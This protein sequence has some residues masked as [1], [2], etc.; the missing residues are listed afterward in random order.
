LDPNIVTYGLISLSVG[1]V[2]RILATIFIAFGDKLNW[3]EKVRVKKRNKETRK[4]S[5]C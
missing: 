2:L 5:N 3:K 1:A 4:I